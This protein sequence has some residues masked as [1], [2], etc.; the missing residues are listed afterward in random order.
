MKTKV[1]TVI[2]FCKHCEKESEFY[3]YHLS[4]CKECRKAYQ[5]DRNHNNPKT[6]SSN[7]NKAHK[8]RAMKKE[9]P[10]NMKA[11]QL[12]ALNERFGNR[13]FLTG[14]TDV[15]I[16]HPIP[17]ATGHG[18]HIVGNVLPMDNSLNI[19]RKDKNF[20]EWFNTLDATVEMHNRFDEAVEYLAALNGLSVDLFREYV[21]YCDKYRRTIEEVKADKRRSVEI[22]KEWKAAGGRI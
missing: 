9:L 11:A 2:G 12:R 1:E 18:G 20:F 21:Y 8:R 16:E 13:C 17:F 14:S 7:K 10:N 5:R 6:K 22:F 4:R 19:S 15:S 3:P